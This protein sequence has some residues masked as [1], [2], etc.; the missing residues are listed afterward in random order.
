MSSITPEQ[1]QSYIE[2]WRLVREAEDAQLRRS[3]L[4]TKLRQLAAL[5]QARSAFGV[6]PERD[7]EIEMVRERW[8][9]IRRAVGV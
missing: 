2:R 4:E 6:H 9:R 1:A 5:M 3:S 7:A 8:A